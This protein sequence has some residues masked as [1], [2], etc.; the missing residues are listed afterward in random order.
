MK[1]LFSLS[2]CIGLLAFAACES[3]VNKQ[4]A[5]ADTTATSG[6]TSTAAKDTEHTSQNSVDWAGTYKGVIPCADCP[7][8]ETTVVLN[9]D[10]TF[11]YT[12]VYQERDSKIEDAGKFMWHD[13]GSVVH[14]M[15]KEV[16][17]KLK[18]GENQ[19]FSLDQDGKPIDGPLK[20]HYILKKEL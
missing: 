1:K 6:D 18:V 9:D 13:N 10:L 2:L 7:G 17:M 4:G 19:L 12:G 16:N 8:I 15:G 14:L 11:K 3:N 5:G 20:D